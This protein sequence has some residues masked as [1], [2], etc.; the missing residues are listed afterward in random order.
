MK[1]LTLEELEAGITEIRRSPKDLG[2][3]ELIVR[4]PDINVREV[5]QEAELDVRQGLV[6]DTWPIRG[7]SRTTDGSAHPDMQLNIMNAR[8]IALVAH[9]EIAGRLPA[10]SCSSISS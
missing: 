1:H 9:T 4:R 8:A 5:L 6:G 3:L 10:I 2:V 7:S